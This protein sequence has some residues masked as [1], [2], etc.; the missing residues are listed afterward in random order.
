MKFI[1]SKYKINVEDMKSRLLH[2]KTTRPRFRLP[3]TEEQAND[4]LLASYA[5]EVEY[6][7]RK[8]IEDN[9]TKE[10]ISKIAKF[11]TRDTSKFGIM[12][13]GVCGNGKTTMLYAIQSMINLVNSWGCF[14]D[15]NT[16]IRI[17]DAKDVSYFSKDIKRFTELKSQ[18][19]LA[20]EDMG[21]EA[22]EVLDYGNILNPV[23]DLIE[24]RY[25]NQLFTAMTTNLT[26]EQIREKYGNRIADRFNEMLEVLAFKNN[27]YRKFSI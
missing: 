20:I 10:N 16:G 22:T 11:L 25:N 4:I 21:R 14:D 1:D 7:R 2:G 19:M 24:Y 15:N 27:T 17:I 3:M 18:D 12:L 26:S 6:R 13:C 8:F 9:E 5:A 23:I